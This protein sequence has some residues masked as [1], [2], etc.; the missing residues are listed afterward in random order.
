MQD[1]RECDV[2][3]I[4][5]G[6][7]GS[8]IAGLLAQKRRHVVVL[9]KDRFPRF[10]IGESLLPLNLPFFEQ[11]GVVDEL[12]RIGV[13]KPGAEVISDEHG[14]TATFRFDRNPHL[15][16]D[17]SYHV[18]RAVPGCPQVIPNPLSR[19]QTAAANPIAC[20]AARTAENQAELVVNG[21]PS[22]L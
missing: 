2:L 10:H 15:R 14:Q 11:L 22:V 12:E 6:P 19:S 18:R 5:G 3:V 16:I 17:P 7:A 21:S 13:Y 4:G 20:A 1:R 9:E 8:T